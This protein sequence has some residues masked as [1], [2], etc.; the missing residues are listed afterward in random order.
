MQLNPLTMIDP[1][2][3]G[4]QVYLTRPMPLQFLEERLTEID[5]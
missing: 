4:E 2:C 3:Y 1:S 5:S